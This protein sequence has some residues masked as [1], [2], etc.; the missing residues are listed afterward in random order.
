MLKQTYS[1]PICHN[2]MSPR[3]M[4]KCNTVVP[5]N[6]GQLVTIVYFISKLASGDKWVARK[7]YK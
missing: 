5:H 3:V 6:Y 2:E 1:P 7:D 4:K